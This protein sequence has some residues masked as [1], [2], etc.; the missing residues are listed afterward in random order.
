MSRVLLCS[1]ACLVCGATASAQVFVVGSGLARDCFDQ[2]KSGNYSFRS[3][4]ETCSRALREETLTRENRRR[5]HLQ[6]LIDR[7][8][9]DALKADGDIARGTLTTS[10]DRLLKALRVQ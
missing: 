7:Q 5:Y 3:A 8:V 10:F 4:D 1:L 2:V 9:H 6:A